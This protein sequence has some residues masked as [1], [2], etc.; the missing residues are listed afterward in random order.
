MR[1][2]PGWLGLA[3][4]VA[5]L[6]VA[7]AV[8]LQ[9]GCRSSNEETATGVRIVQVF[10]RGADS[11]SPLVVWL[12]GRGGR[13]ERFESFWRDFPGRIEVALPQG[14]TA[15][16]FGYAW[17][18]WPPGITDE[19]LAEAVSASEERLWRA[20]LE[21]AHGRKMIVG[22]FSQGGVLAF[23]LAARHP[24]AIRYAFPVAGLLPTPLLPS[25]HAPRAPVFAM[26]GTA[27]DVIGVDY[28]RAAVAA[29]KKDG[30]VAELRELRGVGHTFTSEMREELVTRI[31]ALIDAKP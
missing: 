21:T 2:S 8:A 30:A 6:A 16:G 25:G 5:A 27:D 11:S 20:L 1:R 26:H 12:H 10:A 15:S 22:G 23:L 29:F 9:S 28:A 4:A 24:D 3:L 13:P 31:R 14:F 17:F 19:D 18:D 7:L